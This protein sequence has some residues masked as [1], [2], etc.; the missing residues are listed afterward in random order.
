MPDKN[1]GFKVTELDGTTHDVWE[2]EAYKKDYGVY[3]HNTVDDAIKRD[4]MDALG[5]GSCCRS[6]DDLDSRC[7]PLNQGE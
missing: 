3:C 6:D 2:I 4:R 7:Q 1:L 5:Y